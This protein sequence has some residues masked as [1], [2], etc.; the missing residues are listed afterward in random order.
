MILICL[1]GQLELYDT[2]L[3]VACGHV[4]VEMSKM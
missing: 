2:E 1:L 3:A 4:N